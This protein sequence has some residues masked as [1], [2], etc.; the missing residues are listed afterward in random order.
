MTK[1]R[2]RR[3]SR[4]LSVREKENAARQIGIA[5][6]ALFALAGAVLLTAA[7]LTAGLGA[8]T[9]GGSPLGGLFGTS[10]PT[11]A[12]QATAG[13]GK[14]AQDA[15]TA[16]FEDEPG[17][18]LPGEETPGT[19]EPADGINKITPRDYSIA[20]APTVKNKTSYDID[21]DAL[22][23][24]ASDVETPG[25]I[26][27]QYGKTA[28]IV[29]I[30]HTHGTECYRAEEQTES[31]ADDHFRSDDP[32]R[33]IVSVGDVLAEVLVK[34]GINTMHCTVMFDKDSYSDAYD[35][36][37]KVVRELVEK[38]PSI[39]YVIDVHRD[40]L[41]G[42]G[43]N[44]AA[45]TEIDGVPYAQFL[46]VIGTDEGGAKHPRWKNCLSAAMKLQ[47]ALAE[48][49]PGVARSISLRR[50]SFNAQY[51]PIS[52]LFEFGTCANTLREAKRTAVLVG[53][54]LAE[55]IAGEPCPVSTDEILARFA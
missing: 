14:K 6:T 50:P 9:G 43:N 37:G 25:E 33:S 55:L 52:L 11:L 51:A 21:T 47:V 53:E 40:A 5:L 10:L 27:A 35:A 42:N 32:L 54:K 19:D 8:L 18:V 45:V 20:A 24:M 44:Y 34:A 36:S 17:D 23:A 16:P 4:R 13:D 48:D 46:M 22:L 41:T 39:R 31:R 29:L 30:V 12:R 49:Y 2:E 38:Y 28:P 1:D 3:P 15:D 7:L 26:Y